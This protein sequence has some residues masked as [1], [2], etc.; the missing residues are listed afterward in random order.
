MLCYSLF[1]FDTLKELGEKIK[2]YTNEVP[3]QDNAEITVSS[4]YVSIDEQLEGLWIQLVS[5]Q[6]FVLLRPAFTPKAESF[7]LY[8]IDSNALSQ[9]RVGSASAKKIK[10]GIVKT[11]DYKYYHWSPVF[12]PYRDK[13]LLLTP[14]WGEEHLPNGIQPDIFQDYWHSIC[15]YYVDEMRKSDPTDKFIRKSLLVEFISQVV[16]DSYQLNTKW[17]DNAGLN[18]VKTYLTANVHLPFSYFKFLVD[19]GYM[20]VSYIK[21]KVRKVTHTI[22]T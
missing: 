4:A 9:Y 20:S 19:M 16:R 17:N 12:L 1:K 18:Q 11:S 8:F 22:Y 2:S 10:Q 21:N 13:W 3:L 6:V 14:Q 5:S 7:L 15:S